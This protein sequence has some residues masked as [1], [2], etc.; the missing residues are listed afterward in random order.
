MP[1]VRVCVLPAPMPTCVGG[2]N[3]GCRVASSL[4]SRSRLGALRVILIV[5]SHART[6]IHPS[7]Y[8]TIHRSYHLERSLDRSQTTE[9][10]DWRPRDEKLY[11]Q[12]ITRKEEGY[13]RI[14]NSTNTFSAS[15]LTRTQ[16]CEN[17]S[18]K[19]SCSPFTKEIMVNQY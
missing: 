13:D 11:K 1:L 5:V 4:L 17:K 9:V 6:Y 7:I 12:V 19:K 16:S 8:L 10:D 15:T 2:L 3:F 14:Y 18:Y